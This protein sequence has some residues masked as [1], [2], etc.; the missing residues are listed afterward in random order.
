MGNLVRTNVVHVVDVFRIGEISNKANVFRPRHRVR[1]RLC[2]GIVGGE[3]EDAHLPVL[4][5]TVGFAEIANRIPQALD[6]AIDIPIMV[7]VI[8]DRELHPIVVFDA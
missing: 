6:D 2:E 8:K 1:E 3:F 7:R 4:I 5:G